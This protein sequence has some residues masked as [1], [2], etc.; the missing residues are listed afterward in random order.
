M[1]TIDIIPVTVEGVILPR[2]RTGDIEHRLRTHLHKAH[3][4]MYRA[5]FPEAETLLTQA[6]ALAPQHPKVHQGWGQL[7]MLAGDY[8]PESWDAVAFGRWPRLRERFAAPF[9]AG[10]AMPGGRLLLWTSHYGMGDLLLFCRMFDAIKAQSGAELWVETPKGLSSLLCR[11]VTGVDRYLEPNSVETDVQA[12]LPIDYWPIVIPLTPELLHRSRYLTPDPD[13]LA[14]D[15]RPRSE[16]T[17]LHVGLHWQTHGTHHMARERTI[18]LRA[19]APLFDLPGVRFYALQPGGQADLAAYGPGIL[20]YGQ[21][22]D[23]GERFVKTAALLLDLDLVIAC[24]SAVN[25]LAGAVGT[26]CW[27]LLPYFHAPYWQV[28]RTDTVWYPQH[29]VFRQPRMGAWAPVVTEVREALTA[30]VRDPYPRD[31][32]RTLTGGSAGAVEG[33]IQGLPSGGTAGA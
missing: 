6:S 18:P 24:D 27:L 28:G 23:P 3:T 2:L 20:D 10:E 14:S 11:G 32:P 30:L 29:R 12:H 31:G 16:T 8:A 7:K 25:H 26:P 13:A 5:Q 17:L 33:A 15:Q 4:F 9:W 21:V 19:L 22:D 1:G